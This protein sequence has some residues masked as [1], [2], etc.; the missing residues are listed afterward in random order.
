MGLLHALSFV[1]EQRID[2]VGNASVHL[3]GTELALTCHVLQGKPDNKIQVKNHF[4]RESVLHE[5]KD[6]LCLSS[7]QLGSALT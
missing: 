2:S 7:H 3:K 4:H 5:I 6:A 1:L